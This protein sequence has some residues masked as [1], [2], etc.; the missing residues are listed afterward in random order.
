MPTEATTQFAAARRARAAHTAALLTATVITFTSP[1]AV[2]EDWPTHSITM[3]TPLAAGSAADVAI[4]AVTDKLA[5]RLGQAIVVD[6]PTGASGT[7]GADRVARSTPDGYTL[8]GCN[9][10]I[11]G[12]LPNLRKVPYDPVKSFRPIG[13]VAVLPT[14][15]LVNPA[16]PIHNT[17]ELLA[18]VKAHPGQL[19]YSSGGVGSPQ[20]IA[21][22]MF[23][24]GAGVQL[25]HIP[26]KGASQAA[27]GLAAGEVDTMFCAIGTVL[28]LVKS[29]KL[30]AIAV[31]GAQR[32]P[33]M[34]DLP[35]VAEAGVPGYDYASWIGIVAPKGVS[36]TVVNKVS[37]ELEGLLHDPATLKRFADQGIDPMYMGPADMGSYMAQDYQRM[38]KVIKDSHM[39][40]E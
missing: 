36:D 35:T 18:Y 10:T 26:Y 40:A 37:H 4:R 9:N 23:E 20:D 1:Y 3:V 13:M 39:A 19:K 15:L 17:Q 5:E 30:R 22:T 7:I 29:G 11:L 31:A 38:A 27:V 34:P 24:A 25:Q 14:L 2:A 6:N 12:V 33:L 8:C 28:P 21:M 16:L 32:T